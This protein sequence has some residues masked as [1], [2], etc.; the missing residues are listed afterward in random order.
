M[1]QKKLM[2]ISLLAAAAIFGGTLCAQELPADAN[3]TNTHDWFHI[4]DSKDMIV[5][6]YIFSTEST[7]FAGGVGVIKQGLFQPQTTAIATAFYGTKQDIVT[8]GVPDTANFSGGLVAFFDYR[9]PKTE[10]LFFSFMGMKSYFP[11]ARHFLNGSNDSDRDRDVFETSGDTDML[12][13]TF[14][15]I[16]PIGE[17]LDN[18]ER[19]YKLKEGFP[20]GREGYGGGTPFVTG[21][22]GIGIETFYEHDSFENYQPLQNAGIDLREWDTNGLRF[23]IEHENTD[24][25]LNPTRGYQFRLRYSRDFGW[26]DSRDTW[27]ALEFKYN[28]YLELPNFSW[29]RQSVLAMS[30]WTAHSFSWDKKSTKDGIDAHRPPPWEGARLGGYNRMRGYENNRFSD[31]SAL[32]FTA[33]YRATLQWNPF[34]KNE[35]IPVAIDWIQIVPF[36]EAGRVNNTYNADLLQDMKFDAG[37]SFRTMAAQVPVRIDIARGDE[38]TNFWVMVFQPFDF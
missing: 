19:L 36:I 4:T 37:I 35:Y 23:F 22:T 27:D 20:V 31:K 26:G 18:P 8:N 2:N 25:N 12:Y 29:T 21:F 11:K 30:L 13:T 1:I 9:I 3:T 15:Y 28:H 33:E 6:P 7:G 34:R 16:L 17:G 10:R 32:Y 5:L 14:R 24:Y 38:G